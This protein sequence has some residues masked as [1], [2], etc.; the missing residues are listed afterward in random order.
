MRGREARRLARDA[1]GAATV[2]AV[3]WLIGLLLIAGLAVDSANA[4]RLRAQM[5]AAADAAALAAALELPDAAAARARAREIARINMPPEAH[6]EVLAAADAEIGGQG[7]DGAFLVGGGGAEAVRVTLRRTRERGNGLGTHLLS[8]AGLE[9]WSLT[10]QAVA[11]RRQGGAAPPGGPCDNAMILSQDRIQA[12]GGNTLRDGVCIHGEAGVHFGGATFFDPDVTVSAADAAD[13]TLGNLRPGSA[14][15]QE[16][17]AG[18]SRAPRLLPELQSRF[19]ALWAALWSS[20][21]ATYSGPLLPDYL[22]GPGGYATV[23][24]VDQG[25]WTVQRGELQPHTIYVVNHGMQLAGGVE[26]EDV[27]IIANG[28]IGVGGGRALAFED[29]YFYANG[30]MNMAGNIAWGDEA[31]YCELGRFHAWLF[32]TDRLSLGGW[33]GRG[34]LFGAAGAARVFSP[35]GALRSSGGIHFESEETVQLGGNVD[36]AGCGAPLESFHDLGGA[37]GGQAAGARLLR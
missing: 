21:A 34:G 3:M 30:Q 7:S 20:G 13:V 25:W 8:L 31:H 14:G 5:Q 4:Y 10:A 35:G 15:P 12:G 37:G 29:V 36:I 11:G 16:V 24:R 1:R 26:A 9:A 19:D 17:T 33:G 22:H 27:A 18:V 6:G 28:R 32:S 23:V 2:W